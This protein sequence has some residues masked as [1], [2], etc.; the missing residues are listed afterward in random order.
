MSDKL[1]CIE[2]TNASKDTFTVKWEDR[3][4]LWGFLENAELSE[5]TNESSSYSIKVVMRTQ[6][7][8]NELDEDSGFQ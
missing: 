8:L 7:Q 4:L 2:M 5:D 6:E 3:E 1:H